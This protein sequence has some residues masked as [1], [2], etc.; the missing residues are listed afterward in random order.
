MG[1][2]SHLGTVWPPRHTSHLPALDAQAL[3]LLY[4]AHWPVSAL[5]SR[6]ARVD[7]V[8]TLQQELC[9]LPAHKNESAVGVV[10][11][12]IRIRSQDS[13]RIRP[14]RFRLSGVHI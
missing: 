8:R 3:P 13:G 11:G 10:G 9:L 5:V 14:A 4:G 1:R 2:S 12:F 7:D 6:P